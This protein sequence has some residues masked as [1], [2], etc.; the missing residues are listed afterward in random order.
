[1]TLSCAQHSKSQ[2]ALG[3]HV[4]NTA[5]LASKFCSHVQALGDL[6]H[7]GRP[8]QQRLHLPLVPQQRRL[9]AALAPP[10]D[11]VQLLQ[12]IR[13]SS[14]CIPFFDKN[15]ILISTLLVET[16]KPVFQ[17]WESCRAWAVEM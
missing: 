17:A 16:R 5:A 14:P 7:D 3:R 1:M 6:R 13:D 11:P 4:H 2:L 10:L 9:G 15:N 8:L 12:G